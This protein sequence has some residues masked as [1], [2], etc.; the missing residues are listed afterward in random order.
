MHP[1]GCENLNLAKRREGGLERG[2]VWMGGNQ[3][4]SG[5]GVNLVETIC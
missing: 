1:A 5:M 3:Q 4:S 2:V